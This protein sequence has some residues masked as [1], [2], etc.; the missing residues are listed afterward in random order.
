MASI[1]EEALSNT[2]KNKSRKVGPKMDLY[3]AMDSKINVFNLVIYKLTWAI[4]CGEQMVCHIVG[5]KKVAIFWT[6]WLVRRTHNPVITFSSLTGA[7]NILV[8]AWERYKPSQHPT[9]LFIKRSA[10]CTRG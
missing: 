7:S 4:T 6:E 3:P 2:L 8:K 9:M 10:M 1:F 5:S